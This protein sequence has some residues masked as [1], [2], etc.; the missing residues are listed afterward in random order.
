MTALKKPENRPPPHPL[1]YAKLSNG[2]KVAHE[3]SF[4][5]I[6][7][8]RTLDDETKR[9]MDERSRSVE[10]FGNLTLVTDAMNPSLGNSSWDIK[11][12]RLDGSLLILN[13]IISK[14]SSWDEQAI[15]SR[16]SHL[17]SIAVARWRS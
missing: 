7:S 8:G 13:R 5:A 1:R 17:A 14:Q 6:I 11:K 12:K 15:E 9:L 4:E 10:T 2:V 16:A 3:S